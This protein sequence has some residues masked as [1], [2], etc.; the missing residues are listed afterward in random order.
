MFQ[1]T[2]G[3][4]TIKTEEMPKRGN[5][6]RASLPDGAFILMDYCG[7]DPQLVPDGITSYCFGNKLIL[8]IRKADMTEEDC[9]T[10][11]SAPLVLAIHPYPCVQFSLKV[12]DVWQSAAPVLPHCFRW[13]NDE[14]APVDEAV[15][16][17]ADTHDSEYMLCRSVELPRKVQDFLQKSLNE[18]RQFLALEQV[19]AELRSKGDSDPDRDFFDY[20]CDICRKKTADFSKQAQSAAPDAITDGIYV[21]IDGQNKQV[22]VRQDPHQEAAAPTDPGQQSPPD[23]RGQQPFAAN[24]GQQPPPDN[25]G[26]QPFAANPGQ[27]PPPDNRGQQPFAANPGQQVPPATPGQQAPAMSDE[28]RRYYDLA[29]QGNADA[30]YNLG[31]C[32]EQGDGVP[33]DYRQAAFWYTRASQQGNAKAMY[34]LGVLHYNGTGMPK[35]KKTAASLFREAAEKGDM[36]A[37]YNIGVAYYNGDGVPRDVKRA[38]EWFRKAASQGHQEAINVLGSK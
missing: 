13:M 19:T 4:V 10:A 29:Q 11:A 30:Q 35:S 7:M 6:L 22:K 14:N 2:F 21:E 34:N 26:Q 3:S 1:Q 12:G 23:N 15:F 32:Y 33:Q 16:L 24:P 9:R 27:Q 25:R 20:L 5:C 31:V 37:Q 36:Y 8:V 38:T 17:F 18:S 28:V